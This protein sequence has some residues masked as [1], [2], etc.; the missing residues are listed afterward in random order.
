[1]LMRRWFPTLLLLAPA[2]LPCLA[3]TPSRTLALEDL[4]RIAAVGDPQV[5]P[6]GAWVAYTVSCADPEKD[7]RRKDLW[8]VSWDGTRRVRLTWGPGSAGSPRWS[9]DGRYLAFL[10]ARGEG[11]PGSQVWLLDRLGGEA[12]PLTHLKGGVSDLAWSPDAKRLVLQVAD[13]EP[14]P[15]PKLPPPLVIDRYHF[16]QDG[17]GYLGEKRTH[18]QLLDVASGKAEPLTTGRFSEEEPAWSPDGG[19]I[20]FVSN[21]TADPDHNDESALYVL[22]AKAGAEPLR[23][24]SHEGPD[25]GRPSWSPDGKWLAFLRGDET[26]F[27]AYNLNRAAVVPA[28][29]GPVRILTAA[30]DRSVQG[31]LVWSPDGTRL[32][33]VVQD[34]R[35]RYVGQTALAGGPV[36]RLTSGARVV[37]ALAPRGGNAFALLAGTDTEPLEV[38]ALEGAALRPLSAHNDWLREVRFGAAEDFTS[39]SS[40]GTE[41]HG[42]LVKPPAWVPGKRRPLVLWIHGGPDMQDEHSFRFERQFLAA[43]GYLV[44]AVNYRGGAGRG[45]AYQKAIYADWGHLEV[46]DLLGAADA[47]VRQGLAD[48]DRL[49]LGG[50]SYGGILTDYVIATDGRFKAAISGAGSGLQLTMYGTDEYVMQ[51]EAELGPPWK[52]PDLWIRLSYPFFHA[53]QI[54]TP[55]LFLGGTQDFNVPV[56]GAE[57]MYQAL[58]SLG[59]ETRLVV[60]P[61]QHHELGPLSYQKDRL[62]RYADWF[63]RHLKP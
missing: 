56:S 62:E 16:K 6:E 8:M 46:Q 42:V 40:D 63:D 11:E 21:R 55:T 43:H 26:R 23:L 19:R 7:S 38:A 41:V 54:K 31:P 35:T 2:L 39:V 25:G 44:L 49:G 4:G 48:P 53:D 52:R 50:W 9:P 10:S 60:Y 17:E 1:M 15:K 33:F 58:R 29:G 22:E 20:A 57:Q 12:R 36:A 47:A 24:T 34:D 14:T 30:L 59:V 37:E 27:T 45:S 13:P 51:Y 61:D 32:T 28:A 18:L 5:S 3:Q